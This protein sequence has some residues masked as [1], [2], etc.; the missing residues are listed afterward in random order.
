MYTLVMILL[1]ALPAG[2]YAVATWQLRPSASSSATF[3]ITDA[4][5]SSESGK[6]VTSAPTR[7]AR[8]STPSRAQT[9][10][11]SLIRSLGIILATLL[12]L[13]FT[14]GRAD[15]FT[16]N[17]YAGSLALPYLLTSLALAAL[18][19]GIRLLTR[20]YVHIRRAEKM[21][22]RR[23][24]ALTFTLLIAAIG[25][26]CLWGTW[27]FLDFFGHMEPEQFMFNLYSPV[28]GAA[29]D[30]M[31]DIFTRPVLL[32]VATLA[33]FA[34]LLFSPRQWVI[35]TDD[36]TGKALTRKKRQNLTVILALALL[37]GGLIYGVIGMQIPAIAAQKL[38]ASSYID[39]NYVDPN[40]VP[41]TF[42]ATKRNLIHIY[43]E[44]AETSYLDKENG[45]Y[46]PENLMPDL[47]ALAD[48]GVHFSHTEKPFGGPHQIFGTAWSSA[49]MTNMNLGVPVKIPE[50]G[51]NY[52]IDGQFLPGAV[53][54][55]DILAGQG[56]NQELLLGCDSHFGGLDVMYKTHGVQ[57]VF[58]LST[59]RKE[60]RVPPD[61]MVWWGFEDNKLYEY[62]KE[63]IT[64]LASQ[65]K[66]FAFIME[67]AD[68]HF[69]DGY[70]EP[71]TEHRFS[72][73][74][75]NVIFHSQKQLT[76]FVRWIQAQPFG[77]NTTVVITGDHLS[78]D[79][80]FF[81]GWDPTYERTTF[82]AFIN[83]AFL[84]NDFQVRSRQYT[85]WDYLPTILASLGV[86]IEGERL[87]LGTNLASTEH[88]LIERDGLAR[89]DAETRKFSEFY[90]RE[91]LEGNKNS[92]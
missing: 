83:P 9:I 61:Y 72:Q 53:G 43:F 75:A 27:W 57:K 51:T 62:A 17:A 21:S 47:T 7:A 73:Q 91:L 30:S 31:T 19:L 16:P 54:Y 14:L 13:R 3:K 56:Y 33:L 82:N 35:G 78:M 26:F 12:T 59:A 65:G 39:E 42:P 36:V 81:T 45:G 80:K 10:A 23:I 38:H 71:E 55:T 66:P 52:G 5:M 15:I 1:W 44:S 41:V 63:E 2:A 34:L 70:L 49:G 89:V 86:D 84:H 25:A 29:N 20:R 28:G 32:L 77:D 79:K 88:T 67:N 8:S 22:T 74:Y 24:V 64:N 76:E 11:L 6:N 40:E 46:M 69:P 90:Q 92:T 87:A 4:R 58:D 18:F 68:T 85:S 60:G 50:N 48:E 37:A